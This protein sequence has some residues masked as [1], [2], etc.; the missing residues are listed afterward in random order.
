MI[1]VLGQDQ[2]A[3]RARNAGLAVSGR[4]VEEDGRAGIDRR[5]KR[6]ESSFGEDQVGEHLAH[7]PVGDRHPAARLALDRI[8]YSFQRHRRRT[9]ILAA[10]QRF[11]RAGN[12]QRR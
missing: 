8:D 4:A 10:F 5:A 11:A 9:G 7:H 12:A 6:L 1:H 2:V 3:N